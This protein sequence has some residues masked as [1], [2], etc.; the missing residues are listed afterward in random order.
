MSA[1]TSRV[2][3]NSTT[4]SRILSSRCCMREVRG[5]AGPLFSRI[6]FSCTRVGM[7]RVQLHTLIGWVANPLHYSLEMLTVS[8]LAGPSGCRVC[9]LPGTS[10]L[11]PENALAGHRQV[12][13]QPLTH[14][15]ANCYNSL[16]IPPNSIRRA[17]SVGPRNS[18]CY[19]DFTEIPAQAAAPRHKICWFAYSGVFRFW[20]W[21]YQYRQRGWGRKGAIKRERTFPLL[22]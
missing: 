2:G 14:F 10:H 4:V 20:I 9:V 8:V 19:R 7:S 6:Y 16:R 1:S 12:S 13:S 21:W 11:H 17:Y 3:L 22:E 18:R 5:L 15:S